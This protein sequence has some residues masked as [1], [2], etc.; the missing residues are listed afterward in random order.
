V[1]TSDDDGAV[2]IIGMAGRFPGA[3]DV[4]TL[5]TRLQEGRQAIRPLTDEELAD[6]DPTWRR[7]P[8]FVPVTAPAPGVEEW[9][10]G[11]FGFSPSEAELLDP[12]HRLFL[13]CAWQA[14]E[15]AG[16]DPR[17]CPGV[18]G[19]FGGSHF[20]TYLL[21]NIAGH[22]HLLR[23]VGR[24]RVGIAN[25][26]DMLTTMVS[27]KLDLRGPSAAI[28]TNCS[29]SMV[30][31]HLACESLLSYESDVMLAGGVA[32]HIPQSEGYVYE[33]GGQYARDG[34]FRSLDARASGRVVGN[35]AGIVVLKRTADALRDGDH[36]Y[37]QVIGSA[38]NNDGIGR[39]GF[40]APGLRGQAEVMVEALSR[41]EVEPSEISYVE[42][43][44]TGTALGDSVE[45]D[46]LSRALGAD[47]REGA[48]PC[49]VGSVK[50]NI[51][52]LDRASGVTGVIKTSLMLRDERIPPQIN[53]ET[54]NPHLQAAAERLT[55]HPGGASWPRG[56]TPRWALVNS[57]G[58]GG[59]NASV[60]LKEA[61][62]VIAGGRP[63]ARPQLI[64]LSARTA[65]AVDAAAVRLADH[66][67]RHPQ[68]SLADVAFTLQAGRTRFP[69]RL[70]LVCPEREAAVA[71]L[72]DP[73]ASDGRRSAVIADHPAVS[74]LI[75]D[76][77]APPPEVAEKLY[78][79]EPA[80]RAAVDRAFGNTDRRQPAW[81]D[82]VHADVARHGL[83]AVLVSW[84]LGSE[85]V[86]RTRDGEQGGVVIEL[87]GRQVSTGGGSSPVTP[88][89]L[90]ALPPECTE[91]PVAS[92][93]ELA[94]RLWLAGVELDW[95]A[96]HAGH[97]PRR[98]S[99]PTYPFERQ[100]FW[101]EPV[102]TVSNRAGGTA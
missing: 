75:T 28:Q 41:A 71:A 19:V 90:P 24:Q 22:E 59:T 38:V 31:I 3:W 94:G 76:G 51:G 101:I 30:S 34:V 68:L 92:L 5:W 80:F 15:D 97:R 4:E 74:V 62:E 13:E 20:P 10:A 48:A 78:D 100:R 93:L 99:L 73:G 42:A 9:D 65:T 86:A 7:D 56:S 91:D 55:V 39:A 83:A 12:Q 11:F 87:G 50:A 63:G 81:A 18:V 32:L 44:G 96:L 26:R 85:L 36:I 47:A 25:E 77:P 17:R 43:H 82:P 89:R 14:L 95:T 16:Y 84:G 45:L 69:H 64:L 46:A 70:A 67:R 23:T 6:L 21:N 52:H 61:P 98:V 27:Y 60:V 72:T 53:F 49:A 79:A 33:D 88:R 58:M 40:V 54:P 66:L 102:R 8:H 35:G 29:S 57:F 1:S 2:A 37:A